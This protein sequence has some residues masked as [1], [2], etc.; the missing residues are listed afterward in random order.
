MTVSTQAFAR[1]AAGSILAAAIAVAGCSSGNAATTVP[2]IT[3]A[4]TTTSA[5][6][7]TS[8]PSP[9]AAPGVIP[10]GTYAARLTQVADM[11]ALIA[12]D[13]KMTAAQ[14]QL[15]ERDFGFGAAKTSQVFLAFHAGQMTESGSYDGAPPEVGARAKYAFP[16]DHTM[17]IQELCCGHTFHVTWAGSAFTLKVLTGTPHTEY[18]I[19]EDRLVYESSPF[20]PVP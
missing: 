17:V 6:I 5:V 20:T 15:I 14:R 10:D 16:N 8:A 19:V 3:A 2:G 18:D 9:S 7:A 13:T 11:Q 12:A 1:R 4:P